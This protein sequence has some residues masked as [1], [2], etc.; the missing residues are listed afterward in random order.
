MKSYRALI[1]VPLEAEND[2]AAFDRASEYVECLV[3]GQTVVGHLELVGQAR[4]Q[5]VTRIVYVD[6]GLGRLM[7]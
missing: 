4:G 5:C 3:D 1:S 6:P 2:D 7:P